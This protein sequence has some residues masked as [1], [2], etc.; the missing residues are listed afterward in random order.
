M[1]NKVKQIKSIYYKVGNEIKRLLVKS[2]IDSEII[3]F[4][5][6]TIQKILDYTFSESTSSSRSYTFNFPNLISIDE[7]TV[8]TGNVNYTTEGDNV[9]VSVSAGNYIRSS[10]SSTK[11][12]KSATDYRTSSSNSFSSSVSYSNDGYSGTLYK[13]GSS[14][15]YS[16]SYTPSDSKTVATTKHTYDRFYKKWN[17][18]RWETDHID[19]ARGG[20]FPIS[21]NENG[22]SG[23]LTHKSTVMDKSEV[24]NPP[25][26]PYIGQIF[27]EE[28]VTYTVTYSGTVTKPSSDT[29]KY[30]QNYSGTIY[31]GGYYYYYK[32]NINIKYTIKN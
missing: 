16:G 23:N 12:S 32:Y 1:N 28:K 18:N 3:D 11:Y 26:Q 29:R 17:G 15:V 6:Y 21:Y 22:Y 10:Y 30:R 9:N 13:S 7:I 25:Y 14:Y 31:K 4:I 20:G 19:W 27:L 2:K 5:K 8:D 24:F